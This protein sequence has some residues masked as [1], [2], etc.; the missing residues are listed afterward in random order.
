MAERASYENAV[1]EQ[2]GLPPISYAYSFKATFL[3]TLICF[4]VLGAQV[5]EVFNLTDDIIKNKL[6]QPFFGSKPIAVEEALADGKRNVCLD[7]S[8]QDAMH[9]VIML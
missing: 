6:G 9:R 3:N 7:A 8:E 5:K 1:E 4:R 2:P